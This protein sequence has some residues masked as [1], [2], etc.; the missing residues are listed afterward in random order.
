MKQKDTERWKVKRMKRCNKQIQANRIWDG[1][2]ISD[3]IELNQKYK[4]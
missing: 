4:R 1:I 3:K 2:L